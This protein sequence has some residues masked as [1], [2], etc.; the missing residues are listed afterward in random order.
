M[1]KSFGDTSLPYDKVEANIDSYQGDPSANY[2]Y[3]ARIVQDL[4]GICIP[5]TLIPFNE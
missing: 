3:P 5:K 4:L 1:Q 2:S